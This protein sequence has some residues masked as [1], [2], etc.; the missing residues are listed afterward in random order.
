MLWESVTPLSS[1]I[2][3]TRAPSAHLAKAEAATFILTYQFVAH[4]LYSHLSLSPLNLFILH[5]RTTQLILSRAEN[6]DL[7]RLVLPPRSACLTSFNMFLSM[8]HSTTP[9]FSVAKFTIEGAG[10]GAEHFFA[11]P[12]LS[13]SQTASVTGPAI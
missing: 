10:E 12:R 6:W 11:P 2:L 13:S 7:K 4:M 1:F 5:R 9:P 3:I 8:F